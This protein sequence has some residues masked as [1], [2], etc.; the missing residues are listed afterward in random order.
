MK[1]A[2]MSAWNATSGVYIHAELV[3][4]EWVKAGHELKVFAPQEEDKLPTARD[5]PFVSRCYSRGKDLQ[6]GLKGLWLD[7]EPLLKSDYGF[8]LLRIW[9]FYQCR[10]LPRYSLR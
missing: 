1:I 4:E 3:G 2:M 5:E 6:G 10:N 9:S 8:L 7:S